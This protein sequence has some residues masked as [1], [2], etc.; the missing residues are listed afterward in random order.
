MLVVNNTTIDFTGNPQPA[1]IMTNIRKP[2]TGKTTFLIILSTGLIN[3]TAAILTIMSLGFLGIPAI[4]TLLVVN[5]VLWKRNVKIYKKSKLMFLCLCSMLIS[6]FSS[7]LMLALRAVLNG[8]KH[9]LVG[10]SDFG[11]IDI[12]GYTL[13][14]LVL[15]AF[16]NITSV[17]VILTG[18]KDIG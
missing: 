1:Q 7:S 10:C 17:I 4:I 18:K 13:V 6:A 12:F 15:L 2:K 5:Y 14:F 9:C 16:G 3:T 11:L 8:G